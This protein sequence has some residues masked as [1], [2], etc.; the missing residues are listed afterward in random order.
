[1]KK[2]FLAF[3]V[4]FAALSF[5]G[6]AG[7]VEP[8]EILSDPALEQ[9]AREVSKQLRCVVCQNQ[10]IDD[11][12]A[13]LAR[14]MRLLVRDRMLAGDSNQDV[15]SYMVNRYGDYVLLEPPLKASTAI[16]WYGPFILIV[17]GFL[18]VVFYYRKQ[19]QGTLNPDGK[20]LSELSS[21]EREKL[22]SVL[23]DNNTDLGN[24][25]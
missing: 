22:K 6:Q 14:D 20:A 12:N 10:S 7:A 4:L 19:S 18:A 21:E 2:L 16:L 11:S 17:L 13:E 15:L 9:R 23:S 5:N 25:Q 1:M 8:D 3:I 24:N